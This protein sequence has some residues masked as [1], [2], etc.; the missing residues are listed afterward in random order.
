MGD[1]PKIK[2]LKGLPKRVVIQKFRDGNHDYLSVLYSP[3]EAAPDDEG[4]ELFGVYKLV[5]EVSLRR[6]TK[7]KWVG[8]KSKKVIELEKASE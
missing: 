3:D 5:E 4:R 7:P 8:K 6:P 1:E 2:E